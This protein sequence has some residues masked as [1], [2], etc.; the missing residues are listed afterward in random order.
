M[1]V[2]LVLLYT[3]YDFVENVIAVR[4]KAK[5][6]NRARCIVRVVCI[7]RKILY[8]ILYVCTHEIHGT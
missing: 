5:V 7:A 4:I 6:G 3:L 1:F 8:S 2:C